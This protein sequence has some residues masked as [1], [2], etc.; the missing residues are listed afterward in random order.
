MPVKR[1]YFAWVEPNEVFNTSVHNREDEKIIRFKIEQME[2]E[3]ATLS[4]D[5]KNPRIGLL[6]AGRKLWAY[7]SY[8]NGTDIVPLFFGRVIGI[9]SNIHR[10]VVT[11]DFVARPSNFGVQKD[12]LAA[13]MREL[14]YWDP[15][16][17]NKEMWEDPDVVLEGRTELWHTDRVDHTLT[18]SDILD[19]EDG[20]LEFQEN[21]VPEDSVSLTFD[22]PPIRRVRVKAEV[23]WTQ[24]VAG[25]GL[26]VLNNYT[27]RSLAAAGVVSGWPKP[28]V[29]IGDVGAS[30]G[31]T[32]LV[33]I[34]QKGGDLGGGFFA[35]DAS[36]ASPYERNI[37][38]DW[39]LWWL[40]RY[41]QSGDPLPYPEPP[42]YLSVISSYS[43]SVSV[44]G[45]NN[46]SQSSLTRFAIIDDYCVVNLTAAYEASRQYK[47]IIQFDVVADAQPI[48]TDPEDDEL[49]E[50]SVGGNDVGQPDPFDEYTGA[51]GSK[52]FRSYFTG[53]R[54][55]QSIQYLIQL[56][57]ANV[58]LRSRAVR[59]VWQCTFDRAAELSLRKNALLHHRLMP[60]G[61]VI[62]KIVGYSITSDGG[63]VFG[64]VTIGSCI[65]YDGSV[66]PTLGDPTYVEDG[67]VS[68]GYQARENQLNVIGAGDIGFVS[69]IQRPNDDGLVFPLR[70]FPFTVRPNIFTESTEELT[71]VPPVMTSQTQG[72]DCGNTTSASVNMTLDTGPYN[73]WLSGIT[74]QVRFRHKSVAGGPFETT[75]Q[76]VT[77]PLKLPKQIDL[78]APAS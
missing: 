64:E 18:T 2:G 11:L 77:T 67:Y 45:G 20:L 52:L 63:R 53:D 36:A 72:D 47:D 10:Q 32:A 14:P 38:D 37:S 1:F 24:E 26:L 49:L 56:A 4:I 15:V 25:A 46:S 40:N 6:N 5:I 23:T 35:W 74:T 76:L 39:A 59:V 51:I 42:F 44:G 7:L 21:E 33:Q 50:L 8:D 71:P 31:G 34:T 70:S 19:G 75:Y 57:R 30:L 43:A 54:G 22:Q 3:F 55:K 9:P 62:G 65:G 69:L 29:R 16:F 73:D 66:E 78:E 27:V 61:Q 13:Q 28:T 17:I 68:D 48:L 12:I 58:I 41:P 60:G